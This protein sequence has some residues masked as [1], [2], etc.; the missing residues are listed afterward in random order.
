MKGI[1]EIENATPER[2]AKAIPVF[3]DALCKAAGVAREPTARQLLRRARGRREGNIWR[4]HP[5]PIVA[6]AEV[7]MFGRFASKLHET[8]V[9]LVDRLEL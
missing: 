8:C 7:Q 9:G 1:C 3:F 2:V 5:E 6:S 4:A